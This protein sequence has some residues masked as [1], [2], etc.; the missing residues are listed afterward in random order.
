MTPWTGPLLSA[1][2]SPSLSSK[3]LPEWPV[4]FCFQHVRSFLAQV[5]LFH[6]S[7][8][9]GLKGLRTTWLGLS[10][11]SYFLLPIFCFHFFSCCC[12]KTLWQK[13]LRKERVYI[14]SSLQGQSTWQG[15]QGSRRLKQ[16]ATS[17]PQSRGQGMNEHQCSL[18]FL[19]FKQYRVPDPRNGHLHS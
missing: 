18:C 16:L 14:S 4:K 7:A 8:T 3:T 12:A 10:Q 15:S 2:L 6:I 1:F 9:N 13:Q 19:H 17:G 11:Q 5:P